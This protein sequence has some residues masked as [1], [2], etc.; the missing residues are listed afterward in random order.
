MRYLT[1]L[2]LLPL[3][4]CQQ[5]SAPV[6][7]PATIQEVSLRTP[8]ESSSWPGLPV[9]KGGASVT[10][11]G[12]GFFGCGTATVSAER[13]RSRVQVAI[14][15][16]DADRPCVANIPAWRPYHV[17]IL[18]LDPGIYDVT[19]AAIGHAQRVSSTV[20]VTP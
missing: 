11:R 12:F 19:V 15:A 14:R 16:L 20:F 3:G 7:V 6:P 5:P 4:S 18:R 1:F 10:I 2:L 17:E 13:R 8:E 9:S